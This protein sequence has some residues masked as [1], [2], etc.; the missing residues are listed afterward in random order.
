MQVPAM[1]SDRLFAEQ[2]LMDS[3]LKK[4]RFKCIEIRKKSFFY[5]KNMGYS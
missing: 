4:I 5:L 2:M 3:K 1:R